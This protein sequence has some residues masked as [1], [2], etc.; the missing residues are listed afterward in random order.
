MFFWVTVSPPYFF[1]Y[2]FSAFYSFYWLNDL[3]I[4]SKLLVLWHIYKLHKQTLSVAKV[5]VHKQSQHSG[6]IFRVLWHRLVLYGRGQM[7]SLEW[8]FWKKSQL[9]KGSVSNFEN[10]QFSEKRAIFAK[11]LLFLKRL[12][13]ADIPPW[14]VIRDRRD[15]GDRRYSHIE[16]VN[17]VECDTNVISRVLLSWGTVS[18]ACH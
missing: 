9:S 16:T 1:F 10:H 6:A 18:C 15:T 7:S 5:W 4:Y 8:I 13:G 11:W 3:S 14:G 17:S 2:S 12:L